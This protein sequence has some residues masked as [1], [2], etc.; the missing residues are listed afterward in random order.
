MGANVRALT[1]LNAFIDCTQELKTA[2]RVFHTMLS[3][4]ICRL[5]PEKMLTGSSSF[6]G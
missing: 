4:G 1:A 3:Q 5:H 2:I 6:V